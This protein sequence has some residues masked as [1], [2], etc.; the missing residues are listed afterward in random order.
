MWEKSRTL[1][2]SDGNYYL[3]WELVSTW[4][5]AELDRKN[6]DDM[7][8]LEAFM[9]MVDSI[10]EPIHRILGLH[11][12]FVPWEWF[13]ENKIGPIDGKFTDSGIPLSS[14]QAFD[15]Y[16]IR[17][18]ILAK[19]PLAWI[20]IAA[21]LDKIDP[22]MIGLRGYVKNVVSNLL[23]ECSSAHADRIFVKI[24][25]NFDEFKNECPTP[26]LIAKMEIA[27]F[28]FDSELPKKLESWWYSIWAVEFSSAEWST[29]CLLSSKY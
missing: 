17:A 18:R 12:Q 7:N 10:T 20:M 15:Q 13:Y 26:A 16:P 6:L 27:F 2:F 25:S 4:E 5:L 22:E 11:L 19:Q 28:Y 23:S 3:N 8:S 24:F 14:R 9:W 21:A 1:E 29:L